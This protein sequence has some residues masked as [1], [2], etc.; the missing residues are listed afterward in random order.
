MILY[1]AIWVFVGIQSPF[2][3][4]C[5]Y[6]LLKRIPWIA[7]PW[8]VVPGISSV[9]AIF[10]LASPFVATNP[11]FYDHFL[12]AGIFILAAYFAF[13]RAFDYSKL[14]SLILS[15]LTMIAIDALWQLPIDIVDWSWGWHYL[16]VGMATAA[17]NLMSIPFLF[18]FV[19]KINGR[20]SL[21]M[22]AKALLGFSIASTLAAVETISVIPDPYFL[23]LPWFLFV[24][25]T[26]RSSRIGAAVIA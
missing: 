21:D 3:I 14:D 22:L 9:C 1:S 20:I 2:L 13:W 10:Y 24:V 8:L 18:Y 17:W 16:E 25:S 5:A 4:F 11:A 12:Y 19:L 26:V 7:S 15:L 6:G 23:V